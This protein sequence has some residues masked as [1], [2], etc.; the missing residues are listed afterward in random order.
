MLQHLSERSEHRRVCPQR[1]QPLAELQNLF[2]INRLFSRKEIAAKMGVSED[3]LSLWINGQ[4]DFPAKR[5]GDLYLALN[6]YAKIIALTLQSTDLTITQRVTRDVHRAPIH[7][8]EDLLM[9]FADIHR[10]LGKLLRG[11]R[12]TPEDVQEFEAEAEKAKTAIDDLTQKVREQSQE[13]AQK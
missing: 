2:I 3:L 8:L 12:L 4:R 1:P 9:S 11:D 5:L 7:L 13:E 6:R 10:V